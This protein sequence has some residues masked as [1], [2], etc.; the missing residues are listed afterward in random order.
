[1]YN[2]VESPNYYNIAQGGQG[3]YVTAGYTEEQRKA[4][5]KKISEALSGEKSPNYGKKLPE[6]TKEKIRNTL[7]NE[8]WTPE[9]RAEQSKRYT[10]KNNP[11]YGR[12]Q[13]PES[14]AKMVAHKDYSF[15]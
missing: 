10:G 15:T 12:K 5:N 7:I 11:M 2:A 3:G 9:R 8:Y 1:L 6:E 13:K 4:T 14:I